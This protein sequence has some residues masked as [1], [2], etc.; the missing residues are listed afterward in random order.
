M[1]FSIAYLSCLLLVLNDVVA[2]ETITVQSYRNKFE[3]LISIHLVDSITAI[4]YDIMVSDFDASVAMLH[5]ARSISLDA[6]YDFGEARCNELLG[7]AHYLAGRYDSS[8]RYNL[9]AI[10][11]YER[12]G[13]LKRAGNTLCLQ[14]YQ[15]KRRNLNEAF[16]YYRK[17]LRM[18]EQENAQYELIGAYDNFGVLFELRNDPDS[19]VM[20]YQKSL[21]MKEAAHDSIG[22]PFSL[23]NLAY[24]EV[25]RK[26]FDQAEM[27][28]NKAY[29]IRK[30]RNDLFGLLENK[31][32]FGDLYKAKQMWNEAIRWYE[33]SNL[34]CDS[35]HYPNQKQYN[36][37][38]LSICFENSGELAKA[39]QAERLSAALRDSLLNEKNSKTIIELEKR[40]ELAE[41]ERDIALLEE[42]NAKRKL[43][44][45]VV[46][47][48]FVLS[49]AG[50]L[51]YSQIQKRK[52]RAEKDAAI[53]K[54]REAGLRAVFDATEEERKRI[55]KD[56][57]D[58]IGQQLSGLKMSWEGLR[59]Q[60]ATSLP[61]ESGRIQQLTKVLDETATEVRSLSHRMMPRSLQE[62]GLLPALEDMLRKSLGLTSIAYRIEHFK[63]ESERYNER[64]ELGI[65]RI[66]Q[67]L[68][69]N[70]IK[71]SGATQVVVQLFRNGNFLIL[72]VEDNGRGFT[73]SK[74]KEGIGLLN[75]ESRIN[76][77]NGDVVWEPSPGSGTV[78]TVRVPLS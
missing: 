67:E 15:M 56:L 53:I 43:Y 33:L 41:K 32:L 61:E 9:D 1:K 51:V 77:V 17:G 4:P 3:N 78:A 16:R 13:D 52:S 19:A 44:I 63:V 6:K 20:F 64:I 36:L 55:A 35:L 65:Y 59:I 37:I 66:C 40:F 39:L 72:M 28:L 42:K 54:E 49:V 14:G 75:I 8:T 29:D 57:H 70:I 68:V 58:G 71:H 2:Q 76:T 48:L 22:I 62:N 10:N 38:Q 34:D 30:K 50:G 5:E 11:I 12:L 27:L 18:L 73:N 7:T 47:G 25:L 31:S 23:N 45:G 74:E 69:N 21:A 46:A 26:N 60:L 24:V